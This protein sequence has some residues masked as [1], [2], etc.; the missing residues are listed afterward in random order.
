LCLKLE[1][2]TR[3]VEE[4]QINEEGVGQYVPPVHI[5]PGEKEPEGEEKGCHGK[6]QESEQEGRYVRNPVVYNR[7]GSGPEEGG[8]ND[9]SHQRLK[10]Q[11]NRFRS[12]VRMM[13]STMLVVM[14]M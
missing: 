13:D 1:D 10:S 4:S 3:P 8:Q 12:R 14:G 11:T 6:A 5:L 2:I 9:I 7:K